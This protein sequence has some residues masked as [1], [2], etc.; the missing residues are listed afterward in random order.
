[1][2]IALLGCRGCGCLAVAANHHDVHFA[3]LRRRVGQAVVVQVREVARG[4]GV[5]GRRAANGQC[6]AVAHLEAGSEDGAVLAWGR[7]KLE[8]VIGDN[9]ANATGGIFEDTALEGYDGCAGAGALLYVMLAGENFHQGGVSRDHVAPV[10]H[11]ASMTEQ[12]S[13]C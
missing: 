11:H 5:E 12:R 4:A 3:A 8:L 13:E 7:V 6:G 2:S 9:V 1:M 10:E